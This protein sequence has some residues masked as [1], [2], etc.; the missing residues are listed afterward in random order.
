MI[1]FLYSIDKALFYFCNGT[2]ANPIFD[3]IMPP[4]TDWNQS[5]IGLAVAGILLILLTWKGGKKGRTVVVL[6]VPLIIISDQISSNVIKFLI[7]R[8][9][10]CHLIDGFP[11]LENI[12]LLVPCG[13][14]F[15]FPSSHASNNFAFA[16]LMSYFYPKVRW[17]VF[18]YACLMGFS[19]I[20]VGVHFPS[21]VMGGGL[22]GVFCATIIIILWKYF[23]KAF[24]PF[25]LKT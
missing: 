14:G 12:H 2:L 6:L 16:T 21:D 4:L 3:V 19:R 1:D 24:P 23:I 5:W 17:L 9:R 10:P 15:S 7:E 22:F 8:P 11:V 13:A 20:S 25:S 18:S